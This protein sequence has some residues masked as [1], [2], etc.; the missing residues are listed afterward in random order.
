[1]E[2][3]PLP[4]V[5]PTQMMYCVQSTPYTLASPSHSPSGP[6]TPL[7]SSCPSFGPDVSYS[8][9]PLFSPESSS[10]SPIYSS[11]FT[12]KHSSFGPGRSSSFGPDPFFRSNPSEPPS[13]HSS[14]RSF[15][16]QV[17]HSVSPPSSFESPELA[18]ALTGSPRIGH[19]ATPTEFCS[20]Q[21][22]LQNQKP[23]S[24]AP[25]TLS[26]LTPPVVPPPLPHRLQQPSPLSVCNIVLAQKS[27]SKPF[28]CHH[29][30]KGFER[31]EHLSRHRATDT[32]LRIL[33]A[34]GIPCFDPPRNLGALSLLR[35]KIQS[36]R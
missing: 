1:M 4:T 2:Q 9:S 23:S 11:S 24:S 21:E 32:H 12:A 6:L 7:V 17:A 28:P 20:I 34:K 29:C 35:P 14:F 36:E 5:I 22:I 18:T 31:S 13:S 30:S 33:K 16:S 3:A 19:Y 26:I 8:R 27:T 15:A 10:Y 25:T